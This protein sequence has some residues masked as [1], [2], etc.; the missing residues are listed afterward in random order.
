MIQRLY[1]ILS[2]YLR[3]IYRY[4]DRIFQED[5]TEKGAQLD[6]FKEKIANFS[7]KYIHDHVAYD[8]FELIP[9]YVKH[10]KYYQVLYDENHFLIP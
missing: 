2:Q 8:M 3:A 4:M 1:A 5:I 10:F 7:K 6:E 9:E